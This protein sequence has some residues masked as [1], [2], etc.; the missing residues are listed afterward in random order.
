MLCFLTHDYKLNAEKRPI[1]SYIICYPVW[2]ISLK[3]AI[4]FHTFFLP[5]PLKGPV[6]LGILL[7]LLASYHM[8][9]NKALFER[10]VATGATSMS[11]SMCA[12]M[13]TRDCVYTG[14]GSNQETV[15]LVNNL[16]KS[17]VRLI[18]RWLSLWAVCIIPHSVDVERIDSH[19]LQITIEFPSSLTLT[20]STA[21]WKG[22]WTHKTS[23]M[24]PQ[25]HY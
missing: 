8:A 23:L 17:W 6:D 18:V 7:A 24:N 16:H 3:A 4:W 13:W 15:L 19:E 20:K 9:G 10:L 2:N 21:N 25:N 22:C 5:L 11:L 1:I 12:W 14:A